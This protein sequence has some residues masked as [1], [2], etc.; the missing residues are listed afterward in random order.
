MKIVIIAGGKGTRLK[1]IARDIPK[2]MVPLNGKPL[3]EY[4]LLLAKRYGFTD[5]TI[6]TGHLG[7]QIQEHFKDGSSRGLNI[8]YFQEKTPLGTAG[9]LKEIS[10]LL[11]EDFF[12]FYGDTAMDIDLP[13]MVRF[14]KEHKALG[15]LFLH[16]NDH[17]YDSDLVEIDQ[18]NKITAVHSKP[19]KAGFY[20]NLVN[21]ALY[22]LNPEIL[23]FI[24][25]GKSSDFGKD[26]FP[27]VLR[28]QKTLN[29][30]VSAEYI[31][32]M[33]TPERY[34][35]VSEA[36]VSGKIA[37]S[38]KQNKR[39][40]IFLDRDGVLNKDTDLL[41]KA[42]DLELLPNV[43]DAVKKIN[44][45]GYLAI[46]ITNQPIIAK[47]LATL[48]ELARIH[49][50]LETLLGEKGAY[51]D[52]IYFCPHHPERGF[53]E[54]RVEYKID[55][56]CRKPKPGMLLQAARDFNIDLTRSYLI[57][58]REPDILAGKNAGLKQ[59][60]LVKS[61]VVEFIPE[62]TAADLK[63]EDLNLAVDWILDKDSL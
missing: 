29:G 2:P 52:A 18:H 12:V 11:K 39:P 50:K 25:Q 42:E 7:E 55:C 60:I 61:N 24:P 23:S 6:L 32:D 21:A 57:G 53:P 49:N 54:E 3:I 45:S 31:K 10:L 43:P 19:H 63:L 58:D 44:L 62:T 30:Y 15:T 27:A 40:A 59:T 47:N 34:K 36:L 51:V 20:R 35:A 16:P 14:H 22:I 56:D 41:C 13:A 28:A 37:R 46:V 17:P 9:A 33:G 1:D 48:E 38:N 5:I 26:I 4:Q 8:T